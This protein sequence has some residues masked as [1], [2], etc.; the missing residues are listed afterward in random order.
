MHFYLQLDKVKH[1]SHEEFE[2]LN[3]LLMNYRFKKCVY[4][5]LFKNLNEKFFNGQSEVCNDST[6]SNIP[7][8]GS[9]Q[10]FK[11]L[12]CKTNNGQ[13]DLSYISKLFGTKFLDNSSVIA[14]LI[15]ANA[16]SEMNLEITLF[17]F[18]FN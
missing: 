14:I 15:L 2:R 9:F 5:I 8:R 13:F 4:S 17:E 1:I 12:F 7:L 11:C 18:I 3:W 10:R 6:D 16:I